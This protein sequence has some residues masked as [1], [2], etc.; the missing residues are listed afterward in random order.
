MNRCKQC[1][2][3]ILKKNRDNLFT[4]FCNIACKRDYE[5]S[6]K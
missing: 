5:R 6:Y 3:A 4:K 2:E 1:D